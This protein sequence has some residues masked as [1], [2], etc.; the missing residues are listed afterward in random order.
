MPNDSFGWDAADRLFVVGN[1]T[2]SSARSD[3]MVILK[4]RLVSKVQSAKCK[5]TV[6]GTYLGLLKA[7]EHLKRLPKDLTRVSIVGRDSAYYVMQL[8]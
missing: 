8:T 7:Q 5:K 2:S 3:A 4:G 1:G 6:P